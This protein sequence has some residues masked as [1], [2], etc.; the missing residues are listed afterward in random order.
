MKKITVTHGRFECSFTTANCGQLN[1]FCNFDP[2]AETAFYL[3]IS[4]PWIKISNAGAYDCQPV[5]GYMLIDLNGHS[6]GEF[7]ERL[8]SIMELTLND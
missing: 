2:T 4:Q 3:A 6:E 8:K 7:A 1:V 5:I